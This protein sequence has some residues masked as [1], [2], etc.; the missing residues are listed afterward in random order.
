MKRSDQRSKSQP[1]LCVL[2][3]IGWYGTVEQK[4][5]NQNLSIGTLDE[6]GKKRRAIMYHKQE[7]DI[8]MAI[9]LNLR[10]RKNYVPTHI[11]REKGTASTRN[12]TVQSVDQETGFLIV[13]TLPPT[14][15]YL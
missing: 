14:E 6:N 10:R 15:C 11:A 4:H 1:T 12:Q 7:I 8:A 9:M 3:N 5:S 13:N 2:R